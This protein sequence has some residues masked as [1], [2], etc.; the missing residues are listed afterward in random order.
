MNNRDEIDKKDIR[1]K[2]DFLVYNRN[3]SDVF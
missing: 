3:H 1:D 2:K